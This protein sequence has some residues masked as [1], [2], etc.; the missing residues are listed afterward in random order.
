[1]GVLKP[2]KKLK[3]EAIVNT[4]TKGIYS[5]FTL[6]KDAKKVTGSLVGKRK[7]I[8]FHLRKKENQGKYMGRY[9]FTSEFILTL[10]GIVSLRIHKMSGGYLLRL[11][12]IIWM[13]ECLLEK[14]KS[15]IIL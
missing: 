7:H 3:F 8:I 2:K 11:I 1:M 9:K 14:L 13:K 6:K 12:V 4:V 10:H 5:S 15:F